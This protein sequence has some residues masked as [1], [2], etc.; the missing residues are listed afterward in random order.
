MSKFH[1]FCKS[2]EAQNAAFPPG[3]ADRMSIAQHFGVHTPLLDWTES[4]FAAVF[5]AIREVFTD[6]EFEKT[7]KAYLYHITDEQLLDEGLPEENLLDVGQSAFIKPYHIDKRIE[8]QRGVFTFHP[9]PANR[10]RKIPA[11]VYV[12]DWPVIQEPRALMKGFGFTDDYFFPD[13]A[14]I[15]SA[16]MSDRDLW[17]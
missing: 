10:P 16:V 13:Y 14:G 5:F 17:G 3:V 11:R 12:L 4:I 7:L 2:A 15:A 8:R 1:R 9:F 6:P